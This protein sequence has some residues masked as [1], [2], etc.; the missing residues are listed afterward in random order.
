MICIPIIAESTQKTIDDMARAEPLADLLEIRVDYIKDP[1]LD[2]ILRARTKPVIITIT[3]REENGRFE[4][5]EAERIALLK[6]AVELGADYIDVSIN[7]P[8]LRNI[9]QERAKTKVIVSYHNYRET[10]QDLERIY[11]Q[12]EALE[13]D[14]VKIAT[15]A[16]RL[17]D[18]LRILDL[19]KNS[20]K[21]T[22]AVC[23]G[24]KGEISRILAPFYGSFLTFASLASGRESAPGQI[25][26]STLKD[27]YR[28][29]ELKQG[30]NLYGLIGNPVSKSKGYILF[31]SL[32]REHNLNSLY[33]NFL[34]DDM[35]DFTDHFLR[36]LSGFSVTM[37][38]KQEIMAGLDEIDQAADKIGAVNTVTNIN[39]KLTGYNTDMTGAL[40]PIAQQT[41]IK[42]KAVTLLGAGGAA[43]AIAVGIIAAGGRLTILNRTMEKAERLAAELKCSCGSI[44]DFPK[45]KTDILINMTSV[46]MHPDIDDIPVN[47]KALKEMVVFDGIY[48]PAKTRLLEEAE[49]NGCPIISGQEMF[50]HQAAEQF[51]L[52]T[53]INPEIDLMKSIM[54][55]SS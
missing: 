32:F 50:I 52:F 11:K 21:D 53:G 8:E 39:K 27:I 34:V 22:I 24:P 16:N 5:T 29:K 38:H 2:R 6:R 41:E 40:K 7:C 17:S 37:P 46:G 26:A 28:L 47:P 4:G 3:A 13:G 9:I 18:N 43:R 23:M 51:R 20:T 30:F 19:A 55:C 10:P 48:N 15:F 45:I 33:L 1:D 42:N 35:K 54:Q 25:P 31:N 36:L 44:S 49:M 14:V 12:M